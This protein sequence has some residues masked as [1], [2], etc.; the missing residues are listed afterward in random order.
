MLRFSLVLLTCVVALSGCSSSAKNAELDAYYEQVEQQGK[1]R[2]EPLPPFEQVA[3][4]AYQAG[5][6]RSPFEAPVEVVP[7]KKARL[8]GRQVR[9]DATRVKQY[10][11][12]FNIGQLAMVGTLEQRGQLYALIRDVE[13]GVHRVRAGDYMGADHG[14][15]LDI[16]DTAI[17]LLEIVSDGTGGWVERQRSVSLGGG[18]RG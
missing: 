3:P 10:L 16:N 17:E 15:I 5:G 7:G 2:I 4:F 13:E 6:F 11:E 12:Q 18:D 8:D 14:K 9:P 1:G